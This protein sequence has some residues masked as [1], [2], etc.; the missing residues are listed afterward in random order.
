[1]ESPAS[2]IRVLIVDDSALVRKVL[3][4]IIESAPGLEVVGVA[5]DP[6]Q[7]RTL[8]KEL[9]PDVLTLDVEMPR[10]DGITF[11]S[12]LMRLRPMPVVMVSSLTEPGA[13]V[14]LAALE[15]GAIDFVTKPKL[16]IAEGLEGYADELVGKVRMAAS[17]RPRSRPHADGEATKGA[18][19]SA[20]GL[21]ARVDA[22]DKLI[23]IGASTGGTEAIRQVLEAL[24]ADAPPV[25]VAQHIPEAFSAAFAARLDRNSA[26][27]VC[28]AG[29]RQQITPG[30]VYVAPGNRHLRVVRDGARYTCRLDDGDPVNRH[31]PSVDVLFDSVAEQVGVNAVGV[32][33][34]GMGADGAQG[35]KR[36]SEAG[37]PTIAQ[38]ESTSVVWGMPGEA[39]R[40]GAAGQVLPLAQV[41]TGV[42]SL[43]DGR[44]ASERGAGSVAGTTSESCVP[45]TQLG[46]RK[47]DRT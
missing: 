15:L 27:R 18:S 32:L 40:I 6:Y 10:M 19:I 20:A 14:T 46:P 38:D 43:L 30:H 39:V 4:E 34:T 35:L 12:N 13:E 42:L 1:M 21:M 9:N 3:A 16:D 25:V 29:Q 5:P 22:T 45:T 28:E 26:M 7:A 41:A 23:A 24:P 33:L 37:A 31:K 2:N 11:L 8:I 17:A 47:G 44:R 36:L